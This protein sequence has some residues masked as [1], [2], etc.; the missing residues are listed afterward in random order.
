MSDSN[1]S[2]SNSKQVLNFLTINT[3]VGVRGLCFPYVCFCFQETQV[4]TRIFKSMRDDAI[5]H[6]TKSGLVYSVLSARGI[7]NPSPSRSSQYTS[8]KIVNF[9]L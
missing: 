3:S 5:T 6:H 1:N 8:I 7:L 2:N 9:L 4:E